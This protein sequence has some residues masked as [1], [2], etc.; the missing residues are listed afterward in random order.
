VHGK[1][2][3]IEVLEEVEVVSH[4]GQVVP[5]FDLNPESLLDLVL[6]GASVQGG[7]HNDLIQSQDDLFWDL[8]GAR[9][10]LHLLL[11]EESLRD[12]LVGGDNVLEGLLPQKLCQCF[13]LLKVILGVHLVLD[14]LEIFCRILNNNLE[15]VILVKSVVIID[16]LVQDMAET[17]LLVRWQDYYLGNLRSEFDCSQMSLEDC[18]E[19]QEVQ[20]LRIIDDK[21]LPEDTWFDD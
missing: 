16:R 18:R 17:L 20:G 11:G 2:A 9:E 21:V 13:V 3:V 14:P 4:T 6:H 1:N 19:S 10:I 8:E 5:L 15:A 7:V 12:D